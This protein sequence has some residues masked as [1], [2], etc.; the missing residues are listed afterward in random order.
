MCDLSDLKKGPANFFKNHIFEILRPNG[1]KSA[2]SWLYR[3]KKDKI[4]LKRRGAKRMQC[5]YPKNPWIYIYCNCS[6]W[7]WLQIGFER[8]MHTLL[9]YT[10]LTVLT[11]A[12]S[13]KYYCSIDHD[14]YL[15]CQNRIDS[16]TTYRQRSGRQILHKRKTIFYSQL[17]LQGSFQG[18]S[19]KVRFHVH[20]F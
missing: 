8:I 15:Y 14:H 7:I 19:P 12:R 1:E 11:L 2:I 10:N 17:E 13:T 4:G 9:I 5:P 20:F 16:C 6:L 3:H 18:S